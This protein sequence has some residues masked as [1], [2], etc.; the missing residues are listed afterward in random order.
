MGLEA[1]DVGADEV[2]DLPADEGF[3][4]NAEEVVDV[5]TKERVDVGEEVTGLGWRDVDRVVNGSSL[6]PGCRLC[7]VN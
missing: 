6:D 4:L 2:V 1:V 7:L 3:G 5:G